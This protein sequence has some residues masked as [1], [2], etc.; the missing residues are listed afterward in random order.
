MVWILYFCL[1]IYCSSISHVKE[2]HPV[3]FKNGE[4]TLPPA[5]APWKCMTLKVW[6]ALWS[7]EQIYR[8]RCTDA[9][10]GIW[11]HP[12]PH[13]LPTHICANTQQE[14]LLPV[15]LCQC[16]PS[17]PAF[18]KIYNMI[19]VGKKSLTHQLAFPHHSLRQP[20]SQPRDGK[21]P[22]AL[23]NPCISLLSGD[24]VR[25]QVVWFLFVCLFVYMFHF[26]GHSS[27]RWGNGDR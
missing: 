4:N 10:C 14:A 22:S 9:V 15:V 21:S 1:R 11:C 12:G 2:C 16:S 20:T 27:M 25:S 19:P 6:Q 7:W 18:W 17:R 3:I 13:A 23:Q 8:A 5:V 26:K 24:K